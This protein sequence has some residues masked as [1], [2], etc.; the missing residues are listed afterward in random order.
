M[1]NVQSFVNTKIWIDTLFV[2]PYYGTGMSEQQTLREI[3]REHII[4]VL[5]EVKGNKLKAAE[6]L[7]ISR[8]TLYRRLRSYGLEHLVRDPL[9]GLR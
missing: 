4:R 2:L 1:H 5:K 6:I 3:E 8:G 7:K 9:E